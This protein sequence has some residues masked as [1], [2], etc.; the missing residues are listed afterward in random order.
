MDK[1]RFARLFLDKKAPG[2]TKDLAFVLP[3]EAWID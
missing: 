3:K 2:A 1:I